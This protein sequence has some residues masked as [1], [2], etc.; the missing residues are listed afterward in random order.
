MPRGQP[1]TGAKR[2]GKT[3]T[4]A[5]RTNNRVARFETEE[6]DD[7][8]VVDPASQASQDS[9]DRAMYVEDLCLSLIYD[10]TFARSGWN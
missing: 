9:D 2:G 3:T 10:W 8:P 5:A 4:A 6:S 7:D 1:G